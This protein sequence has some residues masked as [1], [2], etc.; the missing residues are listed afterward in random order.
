MTTIKVAC[1]GYPV[2]QRTYQG[3]LNAVELIQWFD[4]LPKPS[5]LERWMSEAKKDFEFIACAPEVITHP[6]KD[7]KQSFAHRYGFFQDT[8]EVHGAYQRAAVAAGV[9][10]ARTMLFRLP[11]EMGA[12]PEQVDRLTKFFKKV[13]RHKLN[14]VWEPPMNWPATLVTSVSNSLK[15]FPAMNP[16][17]GIKPPTG[18]IRY[19]RLGAGGKTSGV[20]KFSNEELAA[21]KAAC[22]GAPSYVAFNNGP[23]AF[24]DACRFSMLIS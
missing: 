7:D 22:E 11:R 12:N 24:E 9:V 14:F 10:K 23:Y 5:T 3:R 15:L 1:A 4:G 18:L 13:D 20:H 17:A 6:Q 19:F 8:H 21:V 2:S 16:L